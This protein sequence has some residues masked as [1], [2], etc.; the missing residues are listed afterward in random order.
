MA[1]QPKCPECGRVLA[2]ITHYG[3]SPHISEWRQSWCPNREC[4][5]CGEEIKDL[6]KLAEEGLKY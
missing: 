3:G 2:V 6:P 5:R 4:K 1:D